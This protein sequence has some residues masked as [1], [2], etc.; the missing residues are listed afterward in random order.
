M[1]THRK[2]STR[3]GG[4]A[5]A[6]LAAGVLLAGCANDP[7]APVKF[8]PEDNRVGVE[9]TLYRHT[10]D[11]TAD[12]A[13]ATDSERAALERF[14]AE[15]GADRNA[16][17]LVTAANAGGDLAERRRQAV[18]RMLRRQGFDPR[19]TD[20]LLDDHAAPTSDVLVRIARYHVVLPDCPDHS[21]TMIS[22]H[23]NLG[24]SNYGCATNRNLGLMVANPRDLLRGR[25]M[26]PVEGERTAY[27]VR[28]YREGQRWVPANAAGTTESPGGGE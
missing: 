24:S 28:R 25:D 8:G 4:V 5:A 20:P 23:T 13:E 6:L 1:T 22:D 16:T 27:P 21:R 7:D 11:F 15:S 18:I 3:R 14:L 17:V 12:S 26:G 19:H 9:R 2:P 10:V